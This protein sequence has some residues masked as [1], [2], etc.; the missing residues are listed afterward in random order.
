MRSLVGLSERGRDGRSRSGAPSARSRRGPSLRPLFFCNTDV[1]G[2]N[3][4]SLGIKSNM[5]ARAALALR[6]V[7]VNT[8]LPSRSVSIS[9]RKVSLTTAPLGTTSAS[10]TPLGSRAPAARHVHVP[11]GRLLVSSISILRDIAATRYLLISELVR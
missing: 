6:D 2:S 7:I 4:F 8:R 9:A 10:T 1:T 5:P 11:S 3:F